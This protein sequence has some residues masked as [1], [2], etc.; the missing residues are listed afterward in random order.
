[1][2]IIPVYIL[3]T[4]IIANIKKENT[5]DLFYEGA[6]TGLKSSINLIP[7]IIGLLVSVRIFT[8]SGIIEIL[9]TLLN[10]LKIVPE[11]I[12]QSFLR[13]ISANS[14]ILIMNDIFTK[15]GANS[16]IGYI[17]TII[18]GSIDTSFYI[19]TLYYG[20]LKIEVD[21]RIFFIIILTNIIILSLAYCLGLL[22]F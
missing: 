20:S 18:Q 1:M 9:I 15:Y 2:S 17:S 14:S 7:S 22:F 4:I 19:I 3:I 8:E 12:I 5:F 10:N 13:P 11:L 6:I 16:Q 21:K